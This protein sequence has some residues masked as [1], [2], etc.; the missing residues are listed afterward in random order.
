MSKS[1]DNDDQSQLDCKEYYSR[2]KT[3]QL[4]DIYIPYVMSSFLFKD[5]S[6]FSSIRNCT[7][8]FYRENP[9]KIVR[10]Q[11]AYMYDELGNK[12]LDCINNVAHGKE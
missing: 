5:T 4:R 10:C 8:L 11:G 7:E 9:L 6:H 3:L 2:E 1:M 12:Y